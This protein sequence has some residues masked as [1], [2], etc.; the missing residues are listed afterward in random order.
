ME[1]YYIGNEKWYN[2]LVWEEIQETVGKTNRISFLE[3]HRFKSDFK[4]IVE[5]ILFSLNRTTACLIVDT[6]HEDVIDFALQV[7]LN[8]FQ[9]FLTYSCSF[10]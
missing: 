8:I 10:H 6:E 1:I 9:L 7:K 3:S 2:N 5:N 4:A